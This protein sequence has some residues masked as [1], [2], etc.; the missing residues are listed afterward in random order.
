MDD[1]VERRAPGQTDVLWSVRDVQRLDRVWLEV[2]HLS[3][4]LP[5]VDSV[6]D[7]GVVDFLAKLVEGLDGCD[8]NELRARDSH[9]REVLRDLVLILH[10]VLKAVEEFKSDQVAGGDSSQP[11]PCHKAGTHNS[12]SS[13]FCGCV[14][15]RV[16]RR[17]PEIR[18]EA[19]AICRDGVKSMSS[20]LA[21]SNKAGVTS[22]HT[23]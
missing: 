3:P 22:A 19:L 23:V 18:T 10:R 6:D 16:R 17:G 5:R 14:H 2:L 11:W 20:A 13:S 21:G 12:S 15:W 7:E 8:G 9:A 1:E 4:H